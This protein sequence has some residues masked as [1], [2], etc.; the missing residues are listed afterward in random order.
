MNADLEAA[1][2]R[3]EALL[4]GPDLPLDPAQ[5]AAVADDP[6]LAELRRQ[7]D[8][9]DVSWAELWARPK[10]HP[11]GAALVRAVLRRQAERAALG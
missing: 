3:V 8:D 10:A 4:A 7:V 2:A 9:G 5:L 1:L 11:G 6:G